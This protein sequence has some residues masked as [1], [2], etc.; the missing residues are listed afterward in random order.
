MAAAAAAVLLIALLEPWTQTQ[1]PSAKTPPPGS[2]TTTGTTQTAKVDNDVI[3]DQ[4]EYQGKKTMIFTVSK[5][6]TTVIWMYDFDGP[7]SKGGE[8]EEI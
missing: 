8:G 5:N 4:M 2:V 7:G 1:T 6:N 3:I